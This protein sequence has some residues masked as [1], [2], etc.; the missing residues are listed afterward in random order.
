MDLHVTAYPLSPLPDSDET[1]EFTLS[2]VTVGTL[3]G[4]D[5][6][7]GILN[8]FYTHSVPDPDSPPPP[9]PHVKV[10]VVCDET[11]FPDDSLLVG[12]PFASVVI[13]GVPYHCFALRIGS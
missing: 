11:E 8:V 1:A 13:D 6:I 5:V 12:V 4:A 3:T 7:D 2:V 10:L 9:S